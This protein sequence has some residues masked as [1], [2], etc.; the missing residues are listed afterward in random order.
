MVAMIPEPFAEALR[1]GTR[2]AAEVEASSPDRLA[3]VTIWPHHDEMDRQAELE[4]WRRSNPD[5]S[6]HVV[7]REYNREYDPRDWD[8]EQWDV[9][10]ATVEGLEALA[11][12]L[13]SWSVSLTAL[14]YLWK[15]SI[16]E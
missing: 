15:T 5:R 4:G 10:S 14:T 12:L 8:I 3:G 2:L 1:L 13:Q 16:P 6:F 9:A 7:W 11:Q